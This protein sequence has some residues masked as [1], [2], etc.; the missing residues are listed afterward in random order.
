MPYS[1]QH[2]PEDRR[3]HAQRGRHHLRPIPV[4][5]GVQ[6]INAKNNAASGLPKVHV[7]YF[8]L[9]FTTWS[10]L[11]PQSIRLLSKEDQRLVRDQ[12]YQLMHTN[13]QMGM[14]ANPSQPSEVRLQLQGAIPTMQLSDDDGCYRALQ[15]ITRKLH[16]NDALT[17]LELVPREQEAQPPRERD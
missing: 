10:T 9:D 4:A 15:A 6:S 16:P 7:P 14:L 5:P 17:L 3:L 11:G 13:W 2:L 1:D 12:V 8:R